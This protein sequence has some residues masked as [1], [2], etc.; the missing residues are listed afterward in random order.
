ME[1]SEPNPQELADFL[2]GMN[3]NISQLFGCITTLRHLVEKQYVSQFTA[4]SDDPVSACDR[5][6]AEMERRPCWSP[7]APPD[8]PRMLA[9]VVAAE[10]ETERMHRG[11]RERLALHLAD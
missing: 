9:I 7:K 1:D 6:F 11:I 4:E 5:F 8:D 2:N 3:A 10:D